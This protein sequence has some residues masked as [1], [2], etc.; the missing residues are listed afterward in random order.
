MS[1]YMSRC[2]SLNTDKVIVLYI[3]FYIIRRYFFLVI[4]CNISCMP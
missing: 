3:L 1:V 4:F 2:Y